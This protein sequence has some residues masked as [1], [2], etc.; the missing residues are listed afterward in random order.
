MGRI[1]RCG[2]LKIG[3]CQNVH[4]AGVYCKTRFWEGRE[5]RNSNRYGPL[6]AGGQQKEG[7]SGREGMI[8]LVVGRV[9]PPG[10]IRATKQKRS[11]GVTNGTSSHPHALIKA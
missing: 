6:G 11:A 7:K 5:L 10:K 1:L 3:I 2:L 8:V 4:N 9:W